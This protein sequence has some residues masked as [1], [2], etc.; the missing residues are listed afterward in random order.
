MVSNRTSEGLEAL[1]SDSPADAS[2]SGPPVPGVRGID[3]TADIG[4]EVEAPDLPELFRRAV[5]A[6]L[7]LLSEEPQPSGS[8]SRSLDLKGEDLASIL[9][10]CLTEVLY[11]QQVEGFATN[12]LDVHRIEG[13]ELRATASGGPA[14]DAA[15]REI[16]GVTLHGLVVEKTDDGWLARVIFDV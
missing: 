7:W 5:L 12:E 6:T 2:T 14:T 10:A 16:K 3:H 13:R 9:R 11:W 15:V 1:P 8:E 4:L